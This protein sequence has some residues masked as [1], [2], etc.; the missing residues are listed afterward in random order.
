MSYPYLLF[1]ADFLDLNYYKPDCFSLLSAQQHLP[2]S[3]KSIHQALVSGMVSKAPCIS[4]SSGGEK[5]DG[6][7]GVERIC[8]ERESQMQ[9]ETVL[10]TCNP[11]SL[12]LKQGAKEKLLLGI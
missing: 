8:V 6:W 10:H 7:R 3:N 11:S 2:T 5:S 12:G 4:H 9:L 1:S